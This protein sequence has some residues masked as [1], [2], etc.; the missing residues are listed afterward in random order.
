MFSK[1]KKIII[2]SVMVALLVVTGYLNIA[3]NDNLQTV[4]T[5]TNVASFYDTYRDEREDSRG[6]AILYYDSI[7]SDSTSSAEAKALAETSRQKLI[8]ALEQ[9]LLIEGLIKGAGFEDA[10]LSTTSDMIMVVIKAS[11]EDLTDAQVATIATIVT[12]QTGKPLTSIRII[13]SD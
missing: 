7:I 13:P 1:K 9:E 8:A 5:N 10:V 11:A 12:E 6:T 2:L 4:P 3:L